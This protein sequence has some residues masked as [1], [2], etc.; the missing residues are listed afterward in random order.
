MLQ[1]KCYKKKLNF[2]SQRMKAYWQFCFTG[3]GQE[4]EEG[5]GRRDKKWKN[6]KGDGTILWGRH[7]QT[8][9]QSRLNAVE[10]FFLVFCQVP[11]PSQVTAA[12]IHTPLLQCGS[13]IYFQPRDSSQS[14]LRSSIKNCVCSQRLK[15]LGCSA[16]R[17]LADGHSICNDKLQ[18]EVCLDWWKKHCWHNGHAWEP[19]QCRTQQIDAFSFIL[20]NTVCISYCNLRV[21]LVFKGGFKSIF[22]NSVKYIWASNLQKVCHTLLSITQEAL[23]CHSNMLDVQ[24]LCTCNNEMS[25]SSV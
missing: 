24:L 10:S 22:I 1:V 4:E 14:L 5:R 17:P 3:K 12:A 15:Q 7:S 21:S 2:S 13:P 18:Q 20:D 8:L 19:V 23:T 16:A 11:D 9:S 25:P 6:A